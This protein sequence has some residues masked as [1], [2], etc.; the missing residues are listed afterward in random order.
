MYKDSQGVSASEMTYSVYCFRW[1][2]KLYSL[3]HS[4]LLICT[5]FCFFLVAHFYV[6]FSVQRLL[7]IIM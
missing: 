2:V 3:T 6:M 5:L 7:H 4:L 1:G